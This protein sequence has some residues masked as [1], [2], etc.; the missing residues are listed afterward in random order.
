[1][2][3]TVTHKGNHSIP[4]FKTHKS[5]EKNKSESQ[6]KTAENALNIRGEH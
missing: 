1:M 2:H 3:N 6:T 4:L 5:I